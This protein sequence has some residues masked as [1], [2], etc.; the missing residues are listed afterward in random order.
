MAT[1]TLDDIRQTQS[2]L[3][4]EVEELVQQFRT[5]D[6]NGNITK[7]IIAPSIVTATNSP[8]GIVTKIVSHF[9]TFVALPDEFVN[10]LTPQI[11][12]YK[13][14]LDPEG[15]ERNYLLPM[16]KYLSRVGDGRVTTQGVVV[17]SAEFTRLG[18]NPAEIDTNIKFNIKL[19]AKDISVYFAKNETLPMEGRFDAD[20][21]LVAAAINAQEEE[22]INADLR[23]V[24]AVQ[25]A[26]INAQ[27]TAAGVPLQGGGSTLGQQSHAPSI[28]SLDKVAGEAMNIGP[29]GERR[30]AWIDLIK[31]DP[32]QPLNSEKDAAL[33][34][35]TRD[36]R[37]KVEIGY[38][39]VTDKPIGFKGDDDEF[40][41]WRDAIAAQTEVFYLSLFK[42]KF[43]FKGYDGTEL[44]IDF[45]ATGNAKQLSPEADLFHDKGTEE[46]IL[47]L[48]LEIEGHEEELSKASENEVRSGT[49]AGDRF[50]A[51]VTGIEDQV[52]A[53]EEAIL[54]YR[55]VNKLK[56]LNQLY[57]DNV[58][59]AEGK[60]SKVF[61]R[62]YKRGKP[63]ED[64]ATESALKKS[65]SR[66]Q[67]DVSYDFISTLRVAST[68]ST[69][70]TAEQGI[71]SVDLDAAQEGAGIGI[72]RD[73]GDT[74]NTDLFIFLG[75]I[76]ESAIEILV[77]GE[78][79]FQNFYERQNVGFT[80]QAAAAG[81]AG[82]GAA[83][84]GLVAAGVG[85]AVAATGVGLVAILVVGLLWRS[86]NKRAG[87]ETR[88]MFRPPFCW[89][90]TD[91]NGDGLT[92]ATDRYNKALTEFGGILTGTVSYTDLNAT[93]RP[94]P[95][96]TV[97]IRDI[98]IALDIFRSWWI[99][100][101]VKSGK[102]TLP[103]RDFIVALMRFVEKE[104]FASSPLNLG[105]TEERVDDPKFIV[106]SIA[107]SDT[108]F[109]RV[110]YKQ[111]HNTFRN[112]R[113]SAIFPAWPGDHANDVLT[114]ETVDTNPLNSDA[115]PNIIFGETS[116]GI[117]KK[118]DF[119][120]EDIPGHAEARLFSDRTST[121]SN[122]ALREKYNTSYEMV[123]N[124]CFKPG[125][126]LYLDPLPL[127]L[128]YT[129]SRDSLA[130]SIGLGGMYRVVNLTSNLS[131]NASGNSWNTKVNTKW[132][133][134]GDGSN[135]VKAAT[136][137]SPLSL[138]GCVDDELKFLEGKIAEYEALAVSAGDDN[139][140][141][142]KALEEADRYRA[143]YDNLLKAVTPEEQ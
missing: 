116:K 138:G 87:E 137:P 97:K 27:L 65:S 73:E 105:R 66:R 114:I 130:R 50:E 102:K 51:C 123:G 118:V 25:D 68:N 115:V 84:G 42:H 60:Y 38:A 141:T 111:F 9:D 41:K 71:S 17:K 43:D 12:V 119:Q 85:G 93:A 15:N 77:P 106:N 31:I 110:M 72:T 75:D 140:F 128:G 135:G 37:I 107:V 80:P 46:I 124:T 83:V 40:N 81:G 129:Q 109:N 36:V 100:T 8:N 108:T 92:V 67:V 139:A 88:N 54:H 26:A 74:H 30:V 5:N 28:E 70:D 120:R 62:R 21:Q 104:V 86:G 103:L 45:I 125:S 7:N 56:I 98:P 136:E 133:S 76:I 34:T 89:Y 69:D 94:K 1:T 29:N 16:G 61:K 59:N 126:L 63:V 32:G 58:N 134:F 117:L 20:E 131:F 13:T 24:G 57:L 91:S 64:D 132:E 78:Q 44:S 47:K 18:G 95:K 10:S 33:L 6:A 19:F 122:L 35:R 14:Y 22:S 4:S 112:V 2:Y 99:N 82:A 101:Y 39:E 143:L 53:A 79:E 96:K 11:K 55:S 121:A 23:V 113:A 90:S 48:E 52:D 49:D 142:E 127:D 3:L